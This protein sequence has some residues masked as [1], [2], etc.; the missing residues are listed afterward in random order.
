MSVSVYLKN[1]Y[2][3]VPSFLHSPNKTTQIPINYQ[4]DTL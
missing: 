3:N 2:K 1:L 4:M